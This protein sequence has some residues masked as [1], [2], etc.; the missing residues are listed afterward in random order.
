MKALVA[1]DDFTSRQLLQKLLS[2]YGQCD[3]VV[4]GQE[5]IEAH[6]LALETNE[7][8]NLICLDI[9][10]PVVDGMEAL[11]AIRTKEM[12]YSISLQQEVKIVMTTAL[13]SPR[14]IIEAHYGGGCTDYLVKPLDTKKLLKL[15]SNYGL[16]TE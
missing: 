13:D 14:D 9:M 5:A 1:E 8:Y 4:N 7:P 11:K 10:M 6:A 12:S 3:V 2:A 15:I 16:I